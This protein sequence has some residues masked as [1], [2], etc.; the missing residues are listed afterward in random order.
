M[1]LGK[2]RLEFDNIVKEQMQNI[3]C[4]FNAH[5]GFLIGNKFHNQSSPLNKQSHIFLYGL[6]STR[7]TQVDKINKYK[8]FKVNKI[9]KLIPV[10]SS[11]HQ[12]LPILEDSLS[13]NND[14]NIHLKPLGGSVQSP[15]MVLAVVMNQLDT[16]NLLSRQQIWKDTCIRK[17]Q[18]LPN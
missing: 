10:L 11:P 2:T 16:T 4:D 15:H 5:R 9:S 7:K 8:S 12:F 18:N 14:G 13:V 1:D 17:G 6:I 3:P